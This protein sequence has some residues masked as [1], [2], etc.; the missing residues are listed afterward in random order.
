M[1]DTNEIETLCEEIIFCCTEVHKIPGRG[2][3]EHAYQKALAREFNLCNIPYE[4]EH[5]ITAEY[6]SASLD[7]VYRCDF[8]VKDTVLLD[9]KSSESMI[10]KYVSQAI[11]HV[12]LSGN[13]TGPLIT[14]NET[15]LVDGIQKNISF[16]SR[17]IKND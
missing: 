13:P 3:L 8:L 2:V 6:T 11:T 1:T 10:S 15:R 5:D 7:A 16:A 4:L 12:S 17:S 9:I 14:F